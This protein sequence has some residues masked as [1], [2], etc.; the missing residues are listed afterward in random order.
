M[1]EDNEK[2]QDTAQPVSAAIGAVGTS[3]RHNFDAIR[4]DKSVS[5]WVK[6]MK[7]LVW[8]VFV[9]G[10]IGGLILAIASGN[11]GIF[12]VTLLGSWLGSFLAVAGM[13]I[14]LDMA[15]DLSEIKA[16][17]RSKH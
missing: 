14:F 7:I 9:V 6:G 5:F 3:L 10:I 12:I 8:I 16:I 1:P 4:K 17:L 13:M 15:R 11:I 2:Q